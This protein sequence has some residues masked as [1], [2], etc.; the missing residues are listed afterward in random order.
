MAATK[1]AQIATALGPEITKVIQID[2][3]AKF[4]LGGFAPSLLFFAERC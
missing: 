4:S 2:Q 1:F 3:E